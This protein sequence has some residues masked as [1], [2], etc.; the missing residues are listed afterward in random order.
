MSAAV[1]KCPFG[2]LLFA[3]LGG[4]NAS[5]VL[6]SALATADSTNHVGLAL[7]PVSS[8]LIVFCVVS[9]LAATSSCVRPSRWRALRKAFVLAIVTQVNLLCFIPVVNTNRRTK[10]N[11]FRC[12]GLVPQV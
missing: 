4:I 6:S 11:K 2:A 5:G 9:A 8:S 10:H 3:A 12:V 1:T 7:R